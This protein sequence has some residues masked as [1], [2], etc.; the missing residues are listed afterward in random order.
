MSSSSLKYEII[1]QHFNITKGEKNAAAYAPFIFAYLSHG[2]LATYDD[3]NAFLESKGI[4]TASKKDSTSAVRRG[5]GRWNASYADYFQAVNQGRKRDFACGTEGCKHIKKNPTKAHRICSVNN[6]RGQSSIFCMNP[7]THFDIY[8]DITESK[9]NSYEDALNSVVKQDKFKK[10]MRMEPFEHD[11]IESG[12][13]TTVTDSTSTDNSEYGDH[14]S[15]TSSSPYKRYRNNDSGIIGCDVDS[16][17]SNQLTLALGY[18][19]IN[20]TKPDID[21]WLSTVNNNTSCVTKLNDCNGELFPLFDEDDEIDMLL[22]NPYGDTALSNFGF[23]KQQPT[24]IPS[25]VMPRTPII[26]DTDYMDTL[27]NS[28]YDEDKN[29]VILVNPY[30]DTS[31]SNLGF[32]QQQSIFIPS[33]VIP[34]TPSTGVTDDINTYLNAQ[35]GDLPVMVEMSNVEKQQVNQIQYDLILMSTLFGDQISV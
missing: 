12:T 25:A 23:T 8:G 20:T 15:S 21:N 10:R 33:A 14:Y 11:T 18:D 30:G 9:L 26:A 19:N 2:K 32:S 13:D 5:V 22:T 16:L 27:L 24:I 3:M 17:L 6:G 1:S 34:S 7:T 28:L 4:Y 29:D 35:C 31:L